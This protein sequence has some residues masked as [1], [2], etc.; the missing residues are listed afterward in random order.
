MEHILSVKDLSKH[1][2]GLK[3]VSGVSFTIKKGK[4]SGLIG[5]NGSGKTTTLNM[6]SGLLIPTS[7]QIRFEDMDI[8]GKRMA[9]INRMGIARTFQQIRLFPE[10]T[11]LQNVLAACHSTEA[12]AWWHPI[13]M[14]H[15]NESQAKKVRQKALEILDFVGVYEYRNTQAKNLSYG[16]QRKL[17]IA[18]ALATEPKLLLLD[19]PVAGMNPTESETVVSLLRRLRADGMTIILVE[20]TMNV[21]MNICDDIVVLDMGEIIATGK[22]SDILSNQRVIDAYLGKRGGKVDVEN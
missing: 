14:P 19:E 11:C 15:R 18:R 21:V 16:N 4:I 10:L 1:F 8:C 22:P 7:G 2:G 20:H 6:I 13:L 5:P 12:G 3:A 9:Q 17:E